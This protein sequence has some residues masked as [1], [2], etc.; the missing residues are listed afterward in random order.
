M[1]GNSEPVARLFKLP[2]F[3]VTPLFPW[4]GPVGAIPLPSNWIIEFCEPV[5]TEGLRADWQHHPDT[6]S[7]L[8]DQVKRTIQL[9][10]DELLVE[11]GPVFS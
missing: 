3:P 10:L 2:Y 5:P 4:L 8:A 7:S 11:R 6:V 9:K 1:I